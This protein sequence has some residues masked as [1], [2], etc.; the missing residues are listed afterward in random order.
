[1]DASEGG[2]SS[3]F[4]MNDVDQGVCLDESIEK[5]NNVCGVSVRCVVSSVM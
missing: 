4:Q 5:C 3:K 2:V 1:M